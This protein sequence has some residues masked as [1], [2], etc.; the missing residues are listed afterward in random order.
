MEELT[1]A[2]DCSPVEPG[3]FHLE[4]KNREIAECVRLRIE[5]LLKNKSMYF[6]VRVDFTLPQGADPDSANLYA[7]WARVAADKALA[8]QKIVQGNTWTFPE[9]TDY[10]EREGNK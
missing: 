2:L 7:T 5:L 8:A 3:R 10:Y 1:V 6:D 9:G 4:W